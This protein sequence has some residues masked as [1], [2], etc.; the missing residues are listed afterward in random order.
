MLN[1]APRIR[2]RASTIK[3]EAD[4]GPIL[5][6]A[7]G[8]TQLLP[9]I[10]LNYPTELLNGT[11][12]TYIE[13]F[14]GGG[15]VFFDV[16][17]KSQIEKA[18]LVDTNPDLIQ[19][20]RTIQSSVESLIKVLGGLET[21][22]LSLDS[23]AQ[24]E[25]FYRVREDFN[26]ERMHEAQP[27]AVRAAHTVFLN[28]TCFNGLFRVNSKGKFNV[29]F[30]KH[31]NPTILFENRLRAV[32]EAFQCAELI[33][34]DFEIVAPYAGKD[35]FV[36][37]DPPYRPIS[38]TSH[39][40]A[41]SKEA[42]DDLAQT[43]LADFYKSLTAKGVKAMLS[44]SDPTNYIEDPF[45]DDLYQGFNIMRVDAKRMINAKSTGRGSVRELLIKN[46]V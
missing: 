11:I 18:Y 33:L 43:R 15:S 3:G 25:M 39:F 2:T 20:Y 13:P 35:T 12:K 14:F 24:E 28:R 7:G 8:K 36:Y 27:D 34:G 1:V 44:N 38:Q 4:A 32:S 42:F 29:P 6:W 30:G 46:Y 23:S 26:Q 5:K 40:K 17:S 21:E 19:L 37:F 9:I 45:F 22:Y 10:G 16:L 31:K 41:Y